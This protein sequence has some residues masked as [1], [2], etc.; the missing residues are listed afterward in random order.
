ML[1]L[2][3][4]SSSIHISAVVA[5]VFADMGQLSPHMVGAPNLHVFSSQRGAGLQA[6]HRQ[7]HGGMLL[8]PMSKSQ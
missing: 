7:N 3:I 2:M 4:Q 5:G 1:T 6:E 8:K